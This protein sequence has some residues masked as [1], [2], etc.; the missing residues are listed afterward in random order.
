MLAGRGV[1]KPPGQPSSGQLH[2]HA[3][4]PGDLFLRERATKRV[5]QSLRLDRFRV[6]AFSTHALMAGERGSAEPALVLSPA[7]SLSAAASDLLT[8]GET[9]ELKL[10]ANLVLLLGSN[11]AA[12]DG[13]PGAE[14]LTELAK[15]FLYAGSRK[16]VVSHWAVPS[17]AT[18]RLA[19]GM[20]ERFRRSPRMGEAEA[21][22]QAM[23]EVM[24]TPGQPELAHPVFWAPFVLV[25]DGAA[26]LG[27]LGLPP[28]SP[29]SGSP[30]FLLAPFGGCGKP[31]RSLTRSARSSGFHI[32]VIH[33][34][35]GV[36]GSNPGVPT[37]F[38][39]IFQRVSSNPHR[40]L[41]QAGTFPALSA[42]SADEE[43]E[44][45]HQ[46]D[47]ERLSVGKSMA[48]LPSSAGSWFAVPL[49]LSAGRPPALSGTLSS[50]A[51]LRSID[52]AIAF[53]SAL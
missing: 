22:R 7:S 43:A 49:N 14:G 16:L 9:A 28:A 12:S 36:P 2:S 31:L 41:L 24:G 39:L 8:A 27:G 53:A 25:G 48:W 15:A 45:R 6:V 26:S 13:A 10:D 42:A 32:P 37:N 30:L 46:R 33:G 51:T 17:E 44:R 3:R 52:T 29:R 18:T 1:F 11:T 35:Q 23:L 40:A 47:D 50:G 5:L 19:I 4:G 20:F 34:V 38:T 21:L